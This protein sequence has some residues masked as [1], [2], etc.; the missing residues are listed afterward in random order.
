MNKETLREEFNKEFA[1]GVILSASSDL[2]AGEDI[3]WRYPDIH[4]DKVSDW[5][6]SKIEQIRK[7]DV[8]RVRTEIQDIEVSYG[9]DSLREF[10]AGERMRDCIL[11][12]PS[13]QTNMVEVVEEYHKGKLVRCTANGVELPIKQD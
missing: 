3:G 7:E 11:E 10:K 6:L 4:P 8:E 5:W 9:E 1:Y 2:S 12:I 13:L